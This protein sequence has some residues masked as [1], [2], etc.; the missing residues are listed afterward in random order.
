MKFVNLPFRK[1]ATEPSATRHERTGQ[2]ARQR[3]FFDWPIKTQLQI[4]FGAM[5]L[6]AI[7]VG[8]GGLF[9]A[10]V[11]DFLNIT[12][13]LSPPAPGNLSAFGLHVS[14]IKRDYIR[15][16]VR[17]QSTADG[18]EIDAVWA[19]LEAQG[20]HEI[21]AE[22]V[23]E[24][25]IHLARSADMRYIGEGHEVPVTVSTGVTGNAAVEHIWA[26]FHN[27]HMRTFGFAYEGKQDVE[28]VN[29]RVQAVGR[30]HRPAV[31]MSDVRESVPGPD[32]ARAVYWRGQ[33]W[34]ECDIFRR[35]KLTLSN[36]L[37]G[38]LIVE[39]YGSTVV[40]PEGWWV[41]ADAHGNLKLEK[42]T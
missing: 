8:A 40:V 23:A 5:L 24:D 1:T 34:V 31:A 36:A 39:E 9:A 15:T 30:M 3:P 37:E 16:L 32:H 6:C 12:T 14:D 2:P 20:R 18:S 25:A 7:G 19:E 33:G 11:A 26:E 38:P 27:V 41:G 29:L 10:E 17:Q 42:V 21:A 22:G 13:V 4:G 28:V 35:E